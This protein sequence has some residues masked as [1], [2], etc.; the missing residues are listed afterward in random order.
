MKQPDASAG[1]ELR[2]WSG[3]GGASQLH[4]PML[5]PPTLLSPFISS[6][7]CAV[8]SSAVFSP[9]WAQAPPVPL[10]TLP[11]G[12][13]H[14]LLSPALP[15]SPMSPTGRSPH[16]TWAH[17]MGMHMCPCS[18]VHVLWYFYT[19]CARA[20]QPCLREGGLCSLT[21]RQEGQCLHHSNLHK[22]QC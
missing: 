21:H 13:A 17:R 9:P 4:I 12:A 1:S 6:L 7:F 16:P 2:M 11:T 8:P 10:A 18:V 14:K 20:L 19:V 5:I 3:E 15:P 22:R